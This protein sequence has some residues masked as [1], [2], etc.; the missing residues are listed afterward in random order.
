MLTSLLTTEINNRKRKLSTANES[1]PDAK[2]KYF[3]RSDLER[4]RE[5][6]Y[7]KEQDEKIKKEKEKEELKQQEL[8]ERIK[9]YTKHEEQKEIQESDLPREEVIKRLKA[10]GEPITLFGEED[11][12]RADRLRQLESKEPVEYIKTELEG[13]DFLKAMD[14]EM[15]FE[16][17]IQV[18]MK[19][20]QEEDDPDF[21]VE[22]R[23]TTCIEE[24]VSFFFRELIRDMGVELD[25]RPE[26]EK[27]TASGR[28]ATTIFQQTK[29]FLRPLLRM[30]RKKNAPTDILKEL[31]VIV[32][33]LKAKNYI[34]ANDSYYRMAIGNSPWPMG[35]TMVGIHER[36]AREKI[37]SSETAHIL[38]DETQ[39]KYIQAVKR[40]MTFCQQKD[41]A[42]PS[43]NV[44]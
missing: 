1:Q 29:V 44:M 12:M 4:N 30:C 39:R 14:K 6:Q 33:C 5:L 40:L 10:R 23:E 16:Q 38:N 41:P 17:D 26:A 36:S 15:E 28:R 20:K 9:K 21:K 24:E 22:I 31:K 3:K 7:Q 2:K 37:S 34:K 19:K 35:V 43:Q 8:K 42:D 11:A 32:R 25:S 27:K 13:S 18:Q